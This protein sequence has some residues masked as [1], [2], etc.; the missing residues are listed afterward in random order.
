MEAIAD[1][2]YLAELILDIL[3][4]IR[5]NTKCQGFNSRIGLLTLSCS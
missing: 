5:M 4:T 2:S 1:I 3:V